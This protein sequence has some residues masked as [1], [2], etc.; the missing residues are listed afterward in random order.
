MRKL[1]DYL[2]LS[3]LF[4]IPYNLYVIFVWV[5]PAKW[6]GIKGEMLGNV[7][8]IFY[9]HVSS[10]WLMFLGMFL[11]MVFA[12][13]Y[14]KTK[15]IRWDVLSSANVKLALLFG[16]IA[17]IM[18]SIW[19][20]P[21]W[22]V[23][24]TWDPRLTTMAISV[25]FYAGYLT[26]RSILEDDVQARA[27]YSSYLAIVGFLNVPLTFVSIRIWRSLHP[28]VIDAS[29]EGEY[30]MSPEITF[31]LMLSFATLLVLY[32]ILLYITYKVD[33]LEMRKVWS[34]SS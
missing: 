30:G 28:I 19:A 33:M 21:A 15:D 23:F 3:L 34:I 4:L 17:L 16:T 20:K 5:P 1:V 26:F 29:K 18:G 12:F 6:P 27:R 10:A 7:Q 31:A 22:G 11:A 2:L 32:S 13:F 25:L 24:W 9:Y 8:K 14:L